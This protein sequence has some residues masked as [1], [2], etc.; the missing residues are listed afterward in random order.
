MYLRRLGSVL[1]QAAN[2][3]IDDHAAREQLRNLANAHDHVRFAR[4]TRRPQFGQGQ[5]GAQA[6]PEHLVV[7]LAMPWARH[8]HAHL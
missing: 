8:H 4:P 5:S 2:A 1:S 7:A 3:W 6:Q